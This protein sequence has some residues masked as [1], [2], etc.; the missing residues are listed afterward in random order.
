MCEKLFTIRIPSLDQLLYSQT[1]A[2]RVSSCL[3]GEGGGDGGGGTLCMHVL[4]AD[5]SHFS[6]V[7]MWRMIAMRY[8]PSNYII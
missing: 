4:C 7:R 3:G 5:M 8:K 6:Y 1:P 2:G